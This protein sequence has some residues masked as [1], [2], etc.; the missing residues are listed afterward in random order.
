MSFGY[1]EFPAAPPSVQIH[2][3]GGWK[4]YAGAVLAAVG[5][6]FAG[7]VYLGPYLKLTKVVRAQAAELSEERGSSDQM[8]AERDRL[9]AALDQRNGSEREKASAASK[10][11]ESVQD[12]AAELKT[13][14]AA[15]ID[16]DVGTHG[17]ER[18]R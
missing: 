17:R 11:S 2:R 9:K 7:Y 4:L 18:G 12:Y 16:R 3:V 14:L 15:V 1:N 10:R 13:A 5:V 6:G 8:I